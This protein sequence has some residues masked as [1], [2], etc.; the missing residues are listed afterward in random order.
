MEFSCKS[1]YK[2]FKLSDFNEK[3]KD[4]HLNVI[5]DHFKKLATQP[6]RASIKESKI[7]FSGELDAK[8]IKLALEKSNTG[9]EIQCGFCKKKNKFI[10]IKDDEKILKCL[11]CGRYNQF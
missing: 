10:I 11:E 1:C 2:K 4:L 8:L 5:Y 9:I 6:V 3:F 7:G